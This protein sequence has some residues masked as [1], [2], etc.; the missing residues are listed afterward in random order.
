MGK[1]PKIKCRKIKI[2]KG[3]NVESIDLESKGEDE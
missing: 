3:K 2:S 1:M